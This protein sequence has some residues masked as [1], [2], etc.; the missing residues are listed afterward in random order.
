MTM[1]KRTVSFLVSGRGSNFK[2]VAEK[3][4]DG[5]INARFGCVISNKADAPALEIARSMNIPAYAVESK[6]YLT[7]K[8]HEK[9]VCRILARHDTD[10]IVAAGYMRILSPYIISKYR[11]RL[12]NIHPA[13]LPSF[14]GVHA[15][16]QAVEYGVRFSGCTVHFIDEGTDTGPIILQKVVEVRQDDTSAEL[17]K[18][19]LKEEHLLLPEAVK[20]F[21]EN[22][23]TVEGRRVLIK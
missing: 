9:E 4:L 13:L 23:L 12:I 6:K 3:I 2:I 16:K 5:T 8:G 11:Y 15:Q 7:R 17:S 19:I 14:P 10:L 20:L 22:R 1:N 21:C 18:R